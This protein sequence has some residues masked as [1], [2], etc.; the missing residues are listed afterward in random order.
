MSRPSEYKAEF[1]Q[2]ADEYLQQNQDGIEK[3]KLKVKLPTLEGFAIFIGCHKDTLYEWE[4]KYPEF[5]DALNKIRTEQ[6]QRLLNNGLAG[7]YNPTIAK[8]VLSANH[9]MRE[10]SDVTT[11]DKELPTP[12]LNGISTHNGHEEG[13]ESSEQN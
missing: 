2:K 13:S 9:G 4:K 7:T 12:I 8:L 11:N 5:S 3:G 6:Q 10:K 1:V